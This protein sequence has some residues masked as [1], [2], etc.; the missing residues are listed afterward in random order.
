MI[1][2]IIYHAKLRLSAKDRCVNA[3]LH[4]Q[5]PAID[6]VIRRC[7]A[8]SIETHDHGGQADLFINLELWAGLT[9]GHIL[10]ML[11]VLNIYFLR[12]VLQPLLVISVFLSDA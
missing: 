6:I 3:V 9:A 11:P 12:E 1:S 5:L 8:V 7:I 10:H 2:L 4:Q